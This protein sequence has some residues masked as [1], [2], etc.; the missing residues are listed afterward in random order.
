MISLLVIGMLVAGQAPPKATGPNILLIHA[1][2]LRYNSLGYAGDPVAITPNLDKLARKGTNFSNS[3]VTTAICGVSRATLFTGQWQRRHKSTGFGQQLPEAQWKS[4][5]PAL[6]RQAGYHTGFIG[7]IGVGDTPKQ[8]DEWIARFD[9]YRGLPGQ[10]GAEFIDKG[11]PQ[12]RHKTALF[13]D[14]ALEFLKNAPTDKPFVLQ[15][16]FNAPH[17]RDGQP[18]EFTPDPRDEELFKDTQMPVPFL[19][20]AKAFDLLPSFVQDSEGRK[21]WKPRFSNPEKN[22]ATLRDYYRLV[23]GIDR[24]VGRLVEALEASARSK[25]TVLLFTSD[26]GFALGD[27][28]MADKWTFFEE[29]IRVP[30]LIADLR[31]ADASRCRV[32]AIALNTDIAPTILGLAG[33]PIPKTIQGRSLIPFMKRYL[34]MDWRQGFLYEHAS[35]PKAIPPS[36]GIRTERFKYIRWL[37]PDAESIKAGDFRQEQLFDLDA[38]PNELTDLSQLPKNA[39]FMEQMRQVWARE[40]KLLN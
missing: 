37:K 3:F 25:N 39:E 27:R 23:T 18:R 35:G 17:A 2:D 16:S 6:L 1:D 15:V 38:D 14:Q 7:K 9:Y 33:L 34:P 19:A 12:K 8:A 36:E 29:S 4:T 28:G 32:E 26:N 11:D 40:R 10:A 21:R 13:G 20:S 31:D 5:Y 22:Q 24:E 30:L